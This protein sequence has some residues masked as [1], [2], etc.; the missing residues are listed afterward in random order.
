MEGA[1]WIRR[2]FERGQELR[3][4]HGANKVHD[5]SLGNPV[6]DP[7]EEF[8]QALADL[9]RERGTGHHRYMPNAGF[10]DVRE[11]VAGWVTKA[12]IFPARARDVVMSVGAGG[13]LNATLKAI[14]APGDEVLILAPFF[15]EY[16]FYIGNHGGV[17]VTVPAVPGFGIPLEGIEKAIG[18]RTAAVIVNTPNNPCGRVY[19][20]KECR[21]LGD[22][23]R[24]AGKRA[25]RAIYLLS[26]EPYREL[27]FGDRPVPSPA[28]AYENSFFVYSWS[29]ALSIPGDRIGVVAIHPGVD[30]PRLADA[31]TFTTRTLGFVNAPATMQR[32]LLGLLGR[33]VG[34]AEYRAKAEAVGRGLREAGIEFVTPEAGFYVFPK[35]P[36]PDETKFIERLVEE[37]VLVVPGRGFGCPGHFRLS[38]AVSDETIAG[39]M[40][41]IGRAMK[42]LRK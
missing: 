14:L 8:F 3:A 39:G 19:T 10:P 20:E 28:S 37:M 42:K 32:A 27:A 33:S 40:A 35:S 25:G 5:F 15:V 16:P 13:A 4:K 21:T 2:M 18:P 22:L 9:S 38:F 31:I 34:R 7:P 17:P 1:S 6:L 29:K 30:E 11:A 26:D 36:I 41:A 24:A 23:L 12:G